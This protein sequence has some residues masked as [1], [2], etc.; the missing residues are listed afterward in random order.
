MRPSGVAKGIM[1]DVQTSGKA[2]YQKLQ[3]RQGKVA[4]ITAVP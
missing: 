2:G 3:T 4:F 1:W